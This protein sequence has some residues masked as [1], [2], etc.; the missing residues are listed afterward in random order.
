M[1]V[2]N[3][4]Q[5]IQIFD[6][7]FKRDS[8]SIEIGLLPEYCKHSMQNKELLNTLTSCSSLQVFPASTKTEGRNVKS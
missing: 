5:G 8:L 6:P 2:I 1:L 4:C 7:F 3:N